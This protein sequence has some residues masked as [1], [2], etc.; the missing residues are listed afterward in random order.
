M[1]FITIGSKSIRADQIEAVTCYTDELTI[2]CSKN[3]Y[4]IYYDTVETAQKAYKE[5]LAKLEEEG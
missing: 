4:T 1:K 5:V 2:H 3:D